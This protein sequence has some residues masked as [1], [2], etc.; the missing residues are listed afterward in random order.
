MK[1]FTASIIILF[2][3]SILCFGLSIAENAALSNESATSSNETLEN[4]SAAN[5]TGEYTNETLMNTTEDNSSTNAFENVKGR[6][7]KPK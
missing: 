1:R 4:A 6:Q 5:E 7:P 3:L 2:A